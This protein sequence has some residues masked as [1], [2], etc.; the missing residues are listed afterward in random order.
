MEFRE[1]L[2]HRRMVRTFERRPVP[3]EIID[4]LLDAARRAP[5]AGFSQGVDLVVLDTLEAVVR[6]WEVTEDPRF[7]LE[8]GDLEVGPPVIVLAFS[9]PARYLARYSEPDKI[10]FGLDTADAWPVAFWDT[11][12][13]MACMVLLLAAVEEGLGAWFFGIDHGEAELRAE[14]GVPE[15]RNLVGIVGLGY[16]AA[17]ERQTGSAASRPRRPFEE[18]VHR[19]R[20]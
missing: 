13:A 5:T 17:T 3:R 2:R 8:Q 9:D 11:D 10:E 6:F 4:R 14:L 12:A 15:G 7:P 1:V 19:G 20:W 16:A 18:Q